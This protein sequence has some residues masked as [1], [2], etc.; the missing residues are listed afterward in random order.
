M[1]IIIC[2][3]YNLSSGDKIPRVEY[4]DDETKTWT[5]IYNQLS[6]MYP[7]YACKQHI[8][9]IKDLEKAGIYSPDFIPQLE[10]V[11]TFLKRNKTS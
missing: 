9:A 7:K 4:A 6:E 3:I 1:K 10:D 11:S 5:L 2:L 8:D